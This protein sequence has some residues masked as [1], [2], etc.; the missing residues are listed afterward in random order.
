MLKAVKLPFVTFAYIYLRQISDMLPDLA[1]CLICWCQLNN[2]LFSV[3][4]D[5]SD[6]G[7]FP[8]L[9]PVLWYSINKDY[10]LVQ[11]EKGPPSFQCYDHIPPWKP[12]PSYRVYMDDSF[13]SRTFKALYWTLHCVLTCTRFACI[14]KVTGRFELTERRKRRKQLQ[15]NTKT[16]L[17][18]FFVLFCLFALVF[19]WFGN[20]TMR[21]WLQENAIDL[22]GAM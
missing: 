8:L 12:F 19:C 10:P 4:G 17:A 6:H 2:C 3:Y 21:Y 22:F 9:K 18:C 11:Y 15:K 1:D 7:H 14:F 13:P 16:I 20:F 5:E